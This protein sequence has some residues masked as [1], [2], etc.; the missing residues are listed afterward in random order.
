MKHPTLFEVPKDSPSHK[1]RIE[2]FKKR[3][4]IWTHNAGVK[5]NANDPEF[6]PWMAML[7]PKDGEGVERYSDHRCYTKGSDDPFEIIAGY[8]RIIDAGRVAYGKTER[9]AIEILCKENQ[10]LIDLPLSQPT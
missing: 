9:E 8:C 3:V 10:I 6:S 5:A 2:A 4:G 7:L 1:E